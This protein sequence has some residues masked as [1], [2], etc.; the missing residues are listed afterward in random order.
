MSKSGLAAFVF[1]LC[2]A[3]GMAQEPDGIS[4]VPQQY[5]KQCAEFAAVKYTD[6]W[7]MSFTATPTETENVTR[8]TDRFPNV[9][10]W[11]IDSVAR[12]SE[13]FNWLANSSNQWIGTDTTLT[14]VVRKR[15]SANIE[16][17]LVLPTEKYEKKL[18]TVKSELQTEISKWCKMQQPN[19]GSKAMSNRARQRKTNDLYEETKNSSDMVIAIAILILAVVI[20]VVAMILNK[21]KMR[22]YIIDTVLESRSVN[23][24]FGKTDKSVTGNSTDDLYLKF[25]RLEQR[26][27]KL[28]RA[29]E[30]MSAGQTRQAQQPSENTVKPQQPQQIQAAPVKTEIA[31]EEKVIYVEKLSDGRLKDC[32]KERAQY[33]IIIANS[34]NSKFEFCGDLEEAK[35]NFNGTFDGVCDII[36]SVSSSRNYT[37]EQPGEVEQNGNYW[38]VL[39]KTTVK[40]S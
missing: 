40:F 8:Y 5:V 27:D 29:V 2:T 28:E 17:L 33:K 38:R 4:A 21:K 20:L 9:A 34:G 35:S 25:S 10:Q 15:S 37:T 7:I 26:L 22:N 1:C 39:K 23:A 6:A 13:Y 12:F 18:L 19:T 14:E 32:R 31:T 36:G 16:D 24:R 11:T 30:K 3:Y